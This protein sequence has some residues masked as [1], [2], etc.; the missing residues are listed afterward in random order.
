V[1]DEAGMLLAGASGLNPTWMDAQTSAGPVTPRD[2]CPVEI[3][4]L[5]C[6]LLAHLEE[7]APARAARRAWAARRRAAQRA[8]VERFWMPADERLADGW[9]NGARVA[10]L[11]PNMLLAAALELSPLTRSQRRAVVRAAEE[12]L[13]TPRGLRTLSPRDP[14]YVGRY[15]GGPEERDAAYH[16]GTVWPWLLGFYVEAS[17]RALPATRARRAALAALLDGLAAELERAGLGH[18]SEVFDGDA[19][20][21]P[22]GTIA[23]AWNTAEWLRARRM[24]A[25][26]RP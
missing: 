4:A 12:E 17:L 5:W 21:R 26:G 9:R 8:F 3:A 6:S 18:V 13:L 10:A 23:Q 16:Q 15:E 14:A 24:L 7:L 1:V 19:P 20:Q 22:G 25:E 11:R 2:G